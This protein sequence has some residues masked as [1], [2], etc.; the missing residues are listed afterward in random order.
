MHS[1]PSESKEQQAEI[2]KPSSVIKAKKQRKTMQNTR[3]LFKKTGAIKWTFHER[4]GTE[5]GRT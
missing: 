1:Y 4:I 2:R 3:D 5:T